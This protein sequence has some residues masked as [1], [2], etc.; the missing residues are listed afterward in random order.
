MLSIW[1]HMAGG[2]GGKRLATAAG[3]SDDMPPATLRIT[4]LRAKD[5]LA[6]DRGGTSDP[7]A[8]AH[9]G[10]D[11]MHQKKTEVK[12]KTLNPTWMEGFEL[13][14]ASVHRHEGLTVEVFDKD[15]IGAD[16]S[17]GKLVVPLDSLVPDKEYRDWYQLEQVNG[18][19]HPFSDPLADTEE[20]KI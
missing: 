15:M 17:L 12:N 7:Y 18:Y 10:D 9:I 8:R 5:L 4:V 2:V 11:I 20:W 3:D 19:M 14:V 13:H 6:A 16:D 1:E